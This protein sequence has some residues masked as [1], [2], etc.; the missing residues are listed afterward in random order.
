M[1]NKWK[2][3]VLTLCLSCVLLLSAIADG[4]DGFERLTLQIATE[5]PAPLP[6]EPIPI[7]ISVFNSTENPILGYPVIRPNAGFLKIFVASEAE[8][9]KQ[10]KTADWPFV[11]VPSPKKR[12]PLEPG[13]RNEVSG[14]L[15]FASPAAPHR[16]DPNA[17]MEQHL[18][19]SPGIYRVKATLKDRYSNQTIES[20]VITIEVQEPTG[21]NS[22]A[23]D[24]LKEQS[25]PY[26]LM[27]TFGRHWSKRDQAAIRKKEKFLSRFPN[28][29]YA[30]YVYYSLGRT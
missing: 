19:P 9:F 1:V 21:E 20:N 12:T 16:F 26:F 15:Y 4:A 8:R 27:S 11:L 6:M 29:G 22:L 3:R 14:F 10:F 13:Y 2:H 25:Y 5:E 7:T 23:Y 18:L 24:F 28:S 30:R 17:L